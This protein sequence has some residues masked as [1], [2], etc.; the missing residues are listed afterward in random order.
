MKIL[1]GEF[2]ILAACLE[3]FHVHTLLSGYAFNVTSVFFLPACILFL[4]PYIPYLDGTFNQ[5]K[6]FPLGCFGMVLCHMNRKVRY[7]NTYMYG[8]SL[9]ESEIY[10][11]NLLPQ[12][13][14][15]SQISLF[16]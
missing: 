6:P 3:Q 10:L 16:R 13:T 7:G 9:P 8:L 2:W 15:Y 12:L 14:K 1:P 4:P 5:D 11:R